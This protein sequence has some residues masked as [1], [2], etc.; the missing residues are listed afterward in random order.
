[1]LSFALI[2]LKSL[3]QNPNLKKGINKWVE[4]I[5]DLMDQVDIHI[6]IPK[7]R[8][9]TPFLIVVEDDFPTKGHGTIVTGHIERGIIR[10]G[11]IV[12][13]VGLRGSHSTIVTSLEMFQKTLEESIARDNV[14]IL[15]GDVQRKN[16]RRG[17]IIVKLGT[18]KSHIGFEAHV[19]ILQKEE[20]GHHSPFFMEYCLQFYIRITVVTSKIESF[21]YASSG[22]K[23]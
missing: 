1:V 8:I 12:E 3:I 6:S 21:Q 5:Y 19:Y 14:R 23:T 11:E 2:S 22:E 20:G 13:I 17:M 7:H 4:K 18:I 16:I 9:D 15:L 10:V